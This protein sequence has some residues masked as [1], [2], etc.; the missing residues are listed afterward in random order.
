MNRR[1]GDD[2]RK[3]ILKS[4][5]TVFSEHGYSGASMRMIASE[6]SISVGGLYLYFQNKQSLYV[7]IM[8]Q[9]LEDVSSE[10]EAAIG[11]I[12]D[13]VEAITSLVG[14]RLGYAKRHRELIISNSKYQ[15]LAFEVDFKKR[16]FVRQRALIEE[17]IRRG[18]ERGQFGECNVKEAAKIIT[19]ILRGFVF[20]FVVDTDDLFSTEECNHFILNGL[21]RRGG[22]ERTG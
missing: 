9:M 3:K 21:L 16:F 4:A 15:A 13:P 18:I 2:S 14:L 7:T 19:G 11:A 1:S 12:S 8:E 5:L 17:T 10:I 20:S 22:S 6:A